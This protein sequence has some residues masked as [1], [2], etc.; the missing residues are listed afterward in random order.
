MIQ[1]I[2]NGFSLYYNHNF[3]KRQMWKE[4]AKE[5]N[6]EFKIKHN[7]GHEIHNIIIPHKKWD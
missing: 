6:G 7:S 2:I 5:L 1:T 4:F 3:P